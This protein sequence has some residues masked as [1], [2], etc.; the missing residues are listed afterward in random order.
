MRK[1][2]KIYLKFLKYS[3]FFLC[4]FALSP[5]SAGANDNYFNMGGYVRTWASFN[6]NDSLE[7]EDDDT[8]EPSMLRGSVKLDAQ[9]QYGIFLIKVVGRFDHEYETE[10]ARRTESEVH[11]TNS[12]LEQLLYEA[13]SLSNNNGIGSRY[14]LGGLSTDIMDVYNNAELREWF[15]EF[16]PVNRV[17]LRLGKQQIVWGE[18]DFF[19]A[20]DIVQ[21]FDYRWRG[22]MEPENEELRKPLIM[23]NMM[24]Q[25]PEVDGG[26]QLLFRP[27]WDKQD[28]IGNRPGTGGSRWSGTPYRG[29]D[30]LSVLKYNYRYKDGDVRTPTGG[31]RWNGVFGP[32][33]YSFAYLKTY[34]PDVVINSRTDPKHEI[35]N[36]IV[37][38]F[39]HPFI[40]IYGGTATGYVPFL[41]SVLSTEIVFTPNKPYSTGRGSR[42]NTNPN[43][44]V[45]QIDPD[46]DDVPG[47]ITV[48]N[49][50]VIINNRGLN[51]I[52]LPGFGGIK[53]KDTLTTMFRFDKILR[54]L[55]PVLKTGAPPFFS[56]QMFDEW[57]LNFD[58][59]KDQIICASPYGATRKEHST[60]LTAILSL[61]Y[62]N[63]SIK[64][65]LAG[66][67]DLSYDGGFFFP[68][69]EF[70]FGDHWRLRAEVDLFFSNGS[71]DFSSTEIDPDGIIGATG[72]NGGIQ[73]DLEYGTTMFGYFKRRDQFLLRLTYQF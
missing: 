17:T 43:F 63:Q 14:D 1:V 41:D 24:V 66:G 64:P 9:G 40:D 27:G 4:I 65:T 3:I 16:D 44:Y 5:G 26:L 12:W 37:G 69:I 25:F 70:M 59:D 57:I 10:Y 54:F 15:V 50:T 39:V 8:L 11:S 52:D 18:T 72:I 62:F 19:R 51:L 23:A 2:N 47:V 30:F 49:D 33:E 67:Y 56:F 22:F 58:R 53:R 55:Q 46:A 6:L 48:E 71:K 36:G 29:L 61:E 73:K 34:N 45:A 7:T 42:D 13:T 68:S 31:A 38:D 28:Q 21:G 60:M 20:M 32:V 35:P